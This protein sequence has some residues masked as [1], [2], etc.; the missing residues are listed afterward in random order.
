MTTLEDLER[1]VSQLRR[2]V[3]GLEGGDTAA[4]N[5]QAVDEIIDDG[6]DDRLGGE[7][8]FSHGTRGRGVG[9]HKMSEHV[10][11]GHVP[12]DEDKF[13]NSRND[14]ESERKT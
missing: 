4:D 13:N 9:K 1:E 8:R 14:V 6:G 3:R 10:P 12:A 11:I 2:K 7:T 5:A